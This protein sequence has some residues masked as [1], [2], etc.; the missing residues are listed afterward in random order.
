MSLR[1]P[2][3][4]EFAP[5]YA[6][7][8]SA[9][10]EGDV[11]AFLQV[12]Q[13]EVLALFGGFSEVQGAFRYAPGKW[14]LKDL[15]QHL[16]DSERVFTYR[17]LRIGRGDTTPLPG[18]EENAYAAAAHA[19]RR[20]MGDLLAEWQAIRAAS[21]GFFRSLPEAAWSNVGTANGVPVTARCFPYFCAGHTAHH[22][23]ILRERYLP[24]LR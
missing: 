17:A 7:Y 23:G 13:D 11:L 2:T 10:P 15:L 1:R 12:Q 14:T 8:V 24:A 20:T 16:I 4:G 6:P 3:P 19:D 9:V 18:Y 5:S 22:L 21:L